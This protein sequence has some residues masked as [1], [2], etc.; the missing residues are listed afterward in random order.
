M[1]KISM[2]QKNNKRGACV[3]KHKKNRLLLKKALKNKN[4]SLNERFELHAKLVKLPRD[5]SR[6]RVRNRCIVTGRPRG[7]IRK[8][9]M[10]RIVFRKMALEGMLPGV[11]KHGY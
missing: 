9:A 1:A 8:F 4:L 11:V 3:M 7:Y 6:T 2:I 5:S 10:S